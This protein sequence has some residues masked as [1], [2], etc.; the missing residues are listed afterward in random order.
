V[1]TATSTATSTV[2]TLV[3]PNGTAPGMG[4]VQQQQKPVDDSAIG[5]GAGL[6]LAI[7]ALIILV[8]FTYVLLKARRA[9][10]ARPD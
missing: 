7:G 8:V 3:G 6:P 1:D 5:R 9:R 2:T 4:F 10:T